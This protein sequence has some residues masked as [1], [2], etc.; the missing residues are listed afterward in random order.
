M[1]ITNR[2]NSPTTTSSN[3]A[4]SSTENVNAMDSSKSKKKMRR[5]KK[6]NHKTSFMA[7][8]RYGAA[9][10]ILVV[11]FGIIYVVIFG[12]YIYKRRGGH[13]SAL[14]QFN[15]NPFNFANLD[16]D[17]F[18]KAITVDQDGK[19]SFSEED[20]E[21]LKEVFVDV[22]GNAQVPPPKD[23]VGDG[24]EEYVE[25]VDNNNNNNDNNKDNE[26]SNEKGESDDAKGK[27][28]TDNAA[29][30]AN[31]EEIKKDSL[32][33]EEPLQR[34]R[35]SINYEETIYGYG[36]E[37]DIGEM[38]N[39]LKTILTSGPSANF[40]DLLRN[41]IV[42]LDGM[43]SN[44]LSGGGGDQHLRQRRSINQHMF[45]IGSSSK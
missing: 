32:N 11:L 9:L 7:N 19:V 40:V 24:E 1:T 41:K 36:A 16:M 44:H 33:D 20:L 14:N 45:A 23:N 28:Q 30:S 39:N 22:N 34:H 4:S 10:G 42:I 5:S 17:A 15:P 37:E 3:S 2:K 43:E 35:R 8:G 12:N 31:K 27:D 29:D 13:P 18:R 26:K 38:S 6:E 25:D 21:K